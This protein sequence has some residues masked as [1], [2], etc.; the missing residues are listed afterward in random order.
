MEINEKLNIDIDLRNY[1]DDTLVIRVIK[2][3]LLK[4]KII[5]S[6]REIKDCANP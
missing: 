5:T 4:A 1:D 2:V 6:K 3:S